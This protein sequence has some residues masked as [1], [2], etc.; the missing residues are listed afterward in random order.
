[1][2]KCI[3]IFFIKTILYILRVK[4]YFHIHKD[5]KIIQKNIKNNDNIV[6]EIY[7]YFC[8]IFLDNKETIKNIK[9]K[10]IKIRTNNSKL[11]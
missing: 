11:L 8:D 9:H 1:M 10:F 4:N 3:N 5:N 2:H 6:I 7:I